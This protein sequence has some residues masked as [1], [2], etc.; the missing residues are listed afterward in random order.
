MLDAKAFS[1][2]MF[3]PADAKDVDGWTSFMTDDVRFVFG[4]GDPIEGRTTVHQAITAF[5]DSIA[6]IKHTVVDAWGIDDKV[7]QQLRVLYTRHD[8][9]ELDLPAA[10]ILT[11]RDGKVSEY[12][13]YVDN[14]ELY[15]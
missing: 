13:I 2:D 12:L 14:H 8:G 7:V 10:N 9:S 11:L 1:E 5:F 3:R 15:A 4:N 6:A